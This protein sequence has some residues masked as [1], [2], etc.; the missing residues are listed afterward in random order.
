M[1]FFLCL[2]SGIACF[3]KSIN[4][5]KKKTKGIVSIH[6]NVIRNYLW[7]YKYT[8]TLFSKIRTT[9]IY[10]FAMNTLTNRSICYLI[11]YRNNIYLTYSIPE[12]N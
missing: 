8:Y 7:N 3:V 6:Y 10:K 4:V 5:Y 9:I 12:N 1:V 11:I 2:L